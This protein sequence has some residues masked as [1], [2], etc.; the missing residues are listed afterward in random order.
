[1]LLTYAPFASARD[2]LASGDAVV[3]HNYSGDVLSVAQEVPEVRYVIPREGSV[4][5]TDNLA[6]PR[7]APHPRLAH[8]F[9]NF[10]LD[11]EVGAR[12]SSFTRYASPN[13]AALPHLDPALRA[14]PAV[15]PDEAV[16]A[17]L[18]F[19]RDL[20]EARSAYDRIWTRLRAG[21]GG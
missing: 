17:R 10:V 11:A 14:D 13:E 20:G 15:Y 9:V 8:A 16:L 19:L 2:L 3:A 6:I 1:R 21:A 5:W 7:G 12:L 18:E 4:V